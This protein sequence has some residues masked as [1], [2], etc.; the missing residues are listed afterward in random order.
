VG[1]MY[2]PWRLPEA[3]KPLPPSLG[4]SRFVDGSYPADRLSA[5]YVSPLKAL[6]E[7]IRRNLLEPLAS[8]GGYFAARGAVFPE[9]RVETCSGDTPQSQ[10]RHFLHRPPRHPPP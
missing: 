2:W 1:S 10:R 7:D 5:L 6:N 8:L 9:I 3:A 4:R